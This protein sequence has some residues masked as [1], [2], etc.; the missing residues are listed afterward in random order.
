MIAKSITIRVGSKSSRSGG[1]LVQVK[2][3][4]QPKEYDLPNHDYDFSL[5]ELAEP[6]NFN[7]RIQTIAL[8]NATDLVEDGSICLV[9]GW[10]NY[11]NHLTNF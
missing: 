3:I 1:T 8:P 10:G 7:N 4:I 2:Q 11:I 9:S 5:L 6:L